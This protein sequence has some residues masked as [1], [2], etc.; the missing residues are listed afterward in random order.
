MKQR[1][2]F[3]ECNSMTKYLN[4]DYFFKIQG[5]LGSPGSRGLGGHNAVSMKEL[6]LEL[7]NYVKLT[8]KI[9]IL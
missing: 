4:T 5:F 3:T 8:Q 1:I 6:L 2:K 9:S 7:T